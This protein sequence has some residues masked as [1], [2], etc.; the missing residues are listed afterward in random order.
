MPVSRTIGPPCPR[1]GTPL[2]RAATMTIIFAL[3]ADVSAVHFLFSAPITV[4]TNYRHGFDTF[5]RS[6]WHFVDCRRLLGPPCQEK[7]S[8]C[9]R[10]AV[11]LV[12]IT[13]CS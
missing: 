9:R 5:R 6:F 12:P 3:T 1:L 13:N 7:P 10:L 8:A 11:C 4:S 2:A